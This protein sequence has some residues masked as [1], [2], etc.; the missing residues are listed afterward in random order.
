MSLLPNAEDANAQ[1]TMNLKKLKEPAFEPC[2][3]NILAAIANGKRK[4]RCHFDVLIYHE[5]KLKTLG[6][7]VTMGREN[8]I[9][10][11]YK[12]CTDVSWAKTY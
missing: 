9:H 5:D 12:A 8:K 4:T 3:N 1:T 7:K 11:K 10:E 6:Y 2:I